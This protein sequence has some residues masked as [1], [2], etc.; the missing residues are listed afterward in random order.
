ME[1]SALH[2]VRPLW[3]LALL[4]MLFLSWLCW[5][6]RKDAPEWERFMGAELREHLL[7]RQGGNRLPLVLLLCAWLLTILAL[8]GPSWQKLQQPT[9]QRADAL[10]LMLDL[11]PSMYAQDILPSR[12]ERVHN[13]VNDILQRRREGL[14]ALV[15]YG[16]D[17]F[18]I[19]PLT[20]DTEAIGNLL[21]SLS[22]KLLPVQGSN[23][24]AAVADALQLLENSG[25]QRLQGRLLFIT[26]GIRTREAQQLT[27]ILEDEEL[28][29]LILGVG[30]RNGAPV[31]LPA[32]GFLR[33]SGG[34]PVIAAFD[35]APL[36]RLAAQNGGRYHSLSIDDSDIDYLMDESFLHYEQ[37]RETERRFDLWREE[38]PWLLLVLLPLAA[39]GFRRGWLLLLG[40]FVALGVAT[41]ARAFDWQGLWLNRDQQATRA[42]EEGDSARAAELFAHP[43]WRGVALYRTGEYERAMQSW[44][45]EDNAVHHYNRG[46]ALAHAG[47][48]M[49]A[50]KAY[51]TALEI[52]PELEDAQHNLELLL[53][54]LEQAS[55]QSGQQQPGEAG[56]QQSGE[57]QRGEQGPG[58]RQQQ[59]Q[60]GEQ[61]GEQASEAAAGEQEQERR[62]LEQMA[63]E[64][65]GDAREKARQEMARRGDE[66]AES[67]EDGEQE[68]E[69]NEP[70]NRDLS[71]LLED[72]GSL[73]PAGEQE[74]TTEIWL[75][76]VSENPAGLLGNKLL[77]QHRLREQQGESRA[78]KNDPGL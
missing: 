30:T 50:I 31:P 36:R 63:R 46:N 45:V 60:S 62:F 43:T 20:D 28:P 66:Q 68:G 49:E 64:Q 65:G 11:S 26:D 73:S 35:P 25:G 41:P 19:T 32:G 21:R 4:P 18:T 77:Y 16:G 27:R 74:H 58:E 24:A 67:A 53:A 71:S 13:K 78:N 34:A 15:A 61:E 54:A 59:A 56:E 6:H 33:D 7:Q 29:L 38:G 17:S 1:F 37:T 52:D 9:E 10:V 5:T 42:L 3:F 14:T 72:M 70:D 51:R 57:G 47:R 39:I 44:N 23:A 22:P 55:Q 75:R 69:Q 48:I 40:L 8:A 76:R 2:F 12:M